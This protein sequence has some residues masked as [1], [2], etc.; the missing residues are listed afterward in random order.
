MAFFTS[1]VLK[2]THGAADATSC[3]EVGK[4]MPK[5]QAKEMD[6][7]GKA[8]KRKQKD[9]QRTLEELKVKADGTGPLATGGI[10][11]S[12]KSKLFLVPET[13]VIL[14]CISV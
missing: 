5:E 10:Q 13:V 12:G 14:T 2:M 9:E 7:E 4:K 11:T 8:F 1:M 3:H 6:E